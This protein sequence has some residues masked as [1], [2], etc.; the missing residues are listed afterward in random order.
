M[1]K[2]KTGADYNYLTWSG[3]SVLLGKYQ[4]LYLLKESGSETK[5]KTEFI[6]LLLVKII[7]II[8]FVTKRIAEVKNVRT[9]FLKTTHF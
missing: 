1:I 9:F 5:L 8:N 4:I 6:Y 3:V 7:N 2:I